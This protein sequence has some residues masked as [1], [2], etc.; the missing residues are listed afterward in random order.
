MF[1]TFFND[2]KGFT[3]SE[4]LSFIFAVVYLGL[5]IVS[6]TSHIS[7]DRLSLIE[8]LKQPVMVILAGHFGINGVSK[9]ID[10]KKNSNDGE[11]DNYNDDNNNDIVG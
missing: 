2:E 7:P 4:F 11:R 5:I 6:F 10:I 8:L 9:F 1:K 3:I